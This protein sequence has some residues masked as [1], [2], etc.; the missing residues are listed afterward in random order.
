MNYTSIVYSTPEHIFIKSTMCTSFKELADIRF[1]NGNYR[2]MVCV[3]PLCINFQ[4]ASGCPEHLFIKSTMWTCRNTVCVFLAVYK[5]SGCQRLPR[6]QH[7]YFQSSIFGSP[8]VDLDKSRSLSFE[9]EE[10]L[11]EYAKIMKKTDN[12]SV[13]QPETPPSSP[14]KIKRELGSPET[15]YHGQSK[16]AKYVRYFCADI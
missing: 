4:L 12:L 16:K 7:P 11:K 3:F 6:W 8:A 13:E 10:I 5:F 2:N 9:Q 1:Q 14:G 15:P